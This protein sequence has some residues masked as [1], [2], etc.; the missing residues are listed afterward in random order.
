MVSNE[1]KEGGRQEAAVDSSSASFPATHREAAEG[2][3]SL[4]ALIQH[5]PGREGNL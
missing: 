5:G 4:K 1:R 3:R 2:G